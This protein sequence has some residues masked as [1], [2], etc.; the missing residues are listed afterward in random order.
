ME[1]WTGV[2]EDLHDPLQIGRVRV[3]IHGIHTRDKQLIPIKDLPWAAVTLPVTSAAVS[4]KGAAPTGLLKGSWVTGFF[5]D[6]ESK[7]EPVVLGSLIGMST[8]SPKRQNGFNDNNEEWP[9]TEYIGESDV[10]KLARN[11]ELND[12][13]VRKKEQNRITDFRLANTDDVR[14]EP[15]EP[16]ISDYPLVHSVEYE[17]GIVEEVDS[18]YGNVRWQKYHPS[19]TYEEVQ[20]NGSRAVKV[21]GDGYEIF[22][23]HNTIYIGGTATVNIGGAAKIRCETSLDLE[24]HGPVKAVYHDDVHEI[25]EKNL[26]RVVEGNL[27]EAI[28][29]NYNLDVLENLK[30]AIGE[31]YQRSTE[32]E[33]TVLGGGNRKDS[34]DGTYHIWGGTNF[35]VDTDRVDLNSGVTSADEVVEA[36]D[37]VKRNYAEL[38][39]QP[40]GIEPLLPD[41]RPQAR[42]EKHSLQFDEPDNDSTQEW[43]DYAIESGFVTEAIYTKPP[44]IE[45]VIPV[46]PP[47]TDD[48]DVD[49]DYTSE[50]TS[51][52]EFPDTLQL[53]PNFTLGDVSSRAVV[54]KNAVVAQRG[55]SKA[56]IVANLKLVCEKVAEPVKALYPDMF[57]TSGFRKDDFKGGI[58]H[59]MGQAIDIQFSEATTNREYWERALVI[60]NAL[61]G[62]DQFLLEFK[63]FGTKLP[64]IHISYVRNDNRGEVKTMFNHA[65]ITSGTLALVQDEIVVAEKT[66]KPRSKV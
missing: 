64:W 17:G 54:Q 23:R 51:E 21:Q 55:L 32:G 44:E 37:E 19:G 47:E 11:S 27:N 56:E 46:V 45:A 29:K 41:L 59:E 38:E 7:Q 57:V 26:H 15:L 31:D 30:I 34:V 63:N 2:V 39:Y 33:Q 3:R 5:R 35:A 24:V 53:S 28:H 20:N 13:I 8:E 50:F 18:T 6:G 25:Y 52:T 66:L 42:S 60:A 14:T 43:L 62:W 65:V 40:E 36:E 10:N 61:E 49:E 22:A 9:S 58:Q 16:H 1:F 12:T 4:G 48:D